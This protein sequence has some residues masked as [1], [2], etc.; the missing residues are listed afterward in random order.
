LRREGVE[1]IGM[2]SIFT[3]G[4]DIADKAFEAAG[5][6]YLSLTNYNSLIEWDPANW[7]VI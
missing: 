2:V 7:D 3:Y 1:V 4:F 5:V 6:R